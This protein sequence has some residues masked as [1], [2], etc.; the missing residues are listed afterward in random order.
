MLRIS[1]EPY[2]PETMYAEA[3]HD[4]GDG[5]GIDRVSSATTS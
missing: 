5:L 3:E 4:I 1:A 2:D